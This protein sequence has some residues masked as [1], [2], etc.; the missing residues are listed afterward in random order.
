MPGRVEYE[1]GP[2]YTGNPCCS[3]SALSIFDLLFHKLFPRSLAGKGKSVLP[4]ENEDEAFEFCEEVYR[5]TGGP[6]PKLRQA[7]DFHLKNFDAG[8]SSATRYS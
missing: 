4:F 8:R 2:P 6:T 7:Y 3:E 5:E 1:A